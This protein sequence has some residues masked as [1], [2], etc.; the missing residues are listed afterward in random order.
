MNLNGGL[1]FSDTKSDWAGLSLQTPASVNDPVL[2]QVYSLE[3]TNVVTSYS[4]LHYQ[5]VEVNIGGT[6]QFTP[7]LYVAASLGYQIFNDK[8]PYVYGDQDGEAYRSSLGLGY[9]F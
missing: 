5:Q 9:R 3:A 7:E 1:L 2:L 8:S 6:Y 4:D